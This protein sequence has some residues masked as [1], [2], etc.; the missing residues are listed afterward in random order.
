M[1]L[2]GAILV[3][4]VLGY[5][6]DLRPAFEKS[7]PAQV[8]EIVSADKAVK[9]FNVKDGKIVALAKDGT[10]VLDV[11][12]SKAKAKTAYNNVAIYNDKGEVAQTIT[13]QDN[14]VVITAGDKTETIDNA[15]IVLKDTAK[16]K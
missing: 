6:K 16:K 3:V 8:V 14:N 7:A 13:A 12:E 10:L 5:F 9:S 15:A 11:K 2:L 4:A 1:D